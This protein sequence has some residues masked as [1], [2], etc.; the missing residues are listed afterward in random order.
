MGFAEKIK[1]MMER[2]GKTFRQCCQ[3]IGGAGGRAT[4]RNKR[5]C[6]AERARQERMG[7]Q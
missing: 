5:R 7:L 3:Q 1:G 6:R 2:T 4:A